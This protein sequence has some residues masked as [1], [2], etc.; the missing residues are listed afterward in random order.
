MFPPTI[1]VPAYNWAMLNPTSNALPS[2]AWRNGLLILLTFAASA[3]C[4]AAGPPRPRHIILVMADDQGWGQTGYNGHPDLKTPHMDAMAKAGLRMN[5]FYAGGPTCS[6]TRAAVLTGRTHVRTGVLE[7][8]YALRRS[9]RY[10]L[11]AVAR[12]AG[13]QTGHFGK[14]HLNGIR[15]PGI[16]IKSDDRFGP[17]DFGFD[18]WYSVTNF[19]DRDPWMSDQG[20]MVRARGDSSDVA[21]AAAMQFLRR[22]ESAGQPSLSLIWFGSPHS[23]FIAAPEDRSDFA[24]MDDASAN[25]HGEIVAMDRGLGTVRS[26]LD[27]LGITDQTLLWYCSD[28]GGLPKIQPSTVAGLRGHKGTLY[29]GGIRVPGIIQWPGVV[30]PNVTETPATALDILPTICELLIDASKPIDAPEKWPLDGLSLVSWFD[31]PPDARD[32][33]IVFRFRKQS[34]L[35][36]DR[37]KL[38]RTD[39]PDQRDQLYDLIDDP[40]ETDNL[41]DRMPLVHQRIAGA[42]TTRLESIRLSRHGGDYPDG[43]VD[44]DHPEPTSWYESKL[45]R[46][47]IE[48]YREHPAIE[49]WH[50]AQLRRQKSRK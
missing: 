42:L 33:P 4:L 9:E 37:Y 24:A 15:G 28:N 41:V 16:P 17:D 22:C 5:R 6:P 43:T 48:A 3:T 14:W 49:A 11:A 29:E 23:P 35:V 38:I 45:Y 50:D 2:S 20:K 44:P 46:D 19:F 34:A 12:S 13:Y 39:A 21:V 36:D 31:G 1:G 18:R 25:H 40:N 30:A 7:H 27:K 32:H 47:R 8:G 26:T 10:H